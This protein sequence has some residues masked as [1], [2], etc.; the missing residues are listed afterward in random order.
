MMMARERWWLLTSLC[1]AM[2]MGSGLVCHVALRSPSVRTLSGLIVGF[3]YVAFVMASLAHVFCL[4]GWEYLTFNGC[5]STNPDPGPACSMSHTEI[6][7]Y[8]VFSFSHLLWPFVALFVLRS[9]QPL[10]GGEV[11]ATLSHTSE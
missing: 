8:E 9:P 6:R 1:L 10:A 5:Y 4:G 3:G 11:V 7:L 2:Q